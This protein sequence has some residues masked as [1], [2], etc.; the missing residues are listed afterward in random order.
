MKKKDDVCNFCSR[1]NLSFET[2]LLKIYPRNI[3]NKVF[4]GKLFLAVKVHEK[5]LHF[6]C[7]HDF[8]ALQKI[9]CCFLCCFFKLIFIVNQLGVSVQYKNTFCAGSVGLFSVP[10]T[11]PGRQLCVP[12]KIFFFLIFFSFIILTFH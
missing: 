11:L 8:L 2:P 7:K 5:K 4:F 9:H 12:F 1:Y 3:G 10:G 6:L